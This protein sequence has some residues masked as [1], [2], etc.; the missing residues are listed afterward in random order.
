MLQM[1]C[2]SRCKV[3]KEKKK[4][5]EGSMQAAESAVMHKR[6][7]RKAERPRWR[8]EAWASPDLQLLLE[9]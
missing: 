5:S 8:R 2:N 6:G 4:E 3:G 9:W 7:R 1:K